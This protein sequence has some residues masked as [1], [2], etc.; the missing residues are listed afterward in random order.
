MTKEQT[1]PKSILFTPVMK[2]GKQEVRALKKGDWLKTIN[3]SIV[4][5]EKDALPFAYGLTTYPIYTR[6]ET[7]MKSPEEIK[8]ELAIWRYPKSSGDEDATTQTEEIKG[9]IKALTWVLGEESE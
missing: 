2:D 8:K 7:S 1:K 3:G 9:I 6:T 5:A 4:F